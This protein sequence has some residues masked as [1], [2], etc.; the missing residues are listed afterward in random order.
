[1]CLLQ[2]LLELEDVRHGVDEATLNRLTAVHP[3]QETPG[4]AEDTRSEVLQSPVA[5]MTLNV[6]VHVVSRHGSGMANVL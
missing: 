5:D 2:A 4:A 3:Y 6:T 1:M